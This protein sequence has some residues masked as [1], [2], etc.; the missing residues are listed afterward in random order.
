MHAPLHQAIRVHLY[1]CV[2]MR[3]ITIA[4]WQPILS[5]HVRSAS[6]SNAQQSDLT[7][8]ISTYL[9]KCTCESNSTRRRMTDEFD[10]A[11]ERESTRK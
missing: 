5:R 9:I 8:R 6:H 2:F 10:E 7:E 1:K 11:V 3:H 4:G